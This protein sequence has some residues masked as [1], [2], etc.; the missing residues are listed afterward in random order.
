MVVSVKLFNGIYPDNQV[1]LELG[2]AI[3]V[4]GKH[5]PGDSQQHKAKT[6]CQH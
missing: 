3:S 6:V 2:K 4:A 5:G 1:G